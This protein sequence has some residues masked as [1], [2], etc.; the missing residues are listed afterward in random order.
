M[1]RNIC[2]WE[3]VYLAF[4]ANVDRADHIGYHIFPLRIMYNHD[5]FPSPCCISFLLSRI[6]LFL[7]TLLVFSF[8]GFVLS[9]LSIDFRLFLSLVLRFSAF[10]FSSFRLLRSFPPLPFFRSYL[11]I[12]YR[13]S[14]NHRL[15]VFFGQDTQHFLPSNVNN[16]VRLV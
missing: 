12:G 1:S 9:T 6:V 11:T 15:R 8:P 7:F 13:F 2:Q 10:I 4:P 3:I 5:R 16:I 14:V